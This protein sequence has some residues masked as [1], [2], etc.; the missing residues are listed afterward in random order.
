MTE[1]N[2]LNKEIQQI[3]GLKFDDDRFNNVPFSF[4]Q[5]PLFEKELNE[6]LSAE[7]GFSLEKPSNKRYRSWDS[8]IGLNVFDLQ[9]H[10]ASI[11]EHTDDVSPKR[12]FGMYIVKTAQGIH[13]R[14]NYYFDT[15]TEFRYFNENG[16][17]KRTRLNN[18]DLLIFNPRRSHELVFFGEYT[19]FALFDVKA[20][21]K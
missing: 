6:L 2:T 18:G 8:S 11:D 5:F 20:L 19:L 3:V 7:H 12:Y 16:V 1:T 9:R 14:R 10:T 17:K 4:S 15:R 21:K 13:S